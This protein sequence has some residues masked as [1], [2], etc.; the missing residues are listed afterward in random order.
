[1]KSALIDTDILS[2]YFKGN[3]KVLLRFRDYLEYHETINLSS[4]T[5]YEILSGL[6]FKKATK[7]SK[8]FKDFCSSASVINISI[9]S[10]EKSAKIYSVQRFKGE[11]VD[12]IDILIAGIA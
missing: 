10:I 8:I 5:Y 2:Y 11:A 3:D 9:K 1:M 7:Q 12:D 6:R 4:I